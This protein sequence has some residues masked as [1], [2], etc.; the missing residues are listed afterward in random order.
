MRA[1]GR[2]HQIRD[3]ETLDVVLVC[4]FC[5]I[6]ATGG[7]SDIFK[8]RDRD[9]LLRGIDGIVQESRCYSVAGTAKEAQEG[10]RFDK[11]VVQDFKN[12][13]E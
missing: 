9:R 12:A 2:C 7:G 8:L 11:Y 6:A 10:P 1:R 3:E 4:A 5:C 13:N